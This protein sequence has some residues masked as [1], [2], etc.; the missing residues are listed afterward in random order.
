MGIFLNNFKRLT[1]QRA[2]IATV[3]WEYTQKGIL[4]D[5]FEI[6]SIVRFV[7]WINVEYQVS[8]QM[9]LRRTLAQDAAQ[10]L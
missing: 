2:R 10:H 3:D 9:N 7:V 6:R 1:H 4:Y 8:V 5:K